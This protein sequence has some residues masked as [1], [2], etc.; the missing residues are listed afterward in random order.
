MIFE[1]KISGRF[2]RRR[3]LKSL[4]ESLFIEDF[5]TLP[6]SVIAYSDD[7]DEQLES[8]NSLFVECLERHVPLRRVRVTRPPAPWMKSPNIQTLQKERDNLRY[9]AH[10]SDANNGVWAAF[11][12]VRNN[13]KSAIRS[14]RKAFIEKAL[15]SNKSRD[16]WRVIHRILKPNPKSLRVDPD[17]LNAHFATT[18]ERTLE[19][20]AV[21]LSDLT[22][23]L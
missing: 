8:L 20:S 7:P 16:V 22:S 10:K 11:R 9:K 4:N 17:E 14:A 15:S 21:S 18:A 3:P 2:L 6:L 12:L 13:L 19:A 5:S 1:K 23:D